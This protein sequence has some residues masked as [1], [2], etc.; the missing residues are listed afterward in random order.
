MRTWKDYKNNPNVINEAKVVIKTIEGA[1]DYALENSK[2]K[3]EA[4]AFIS[5]TKDAFIVKNLQQIKEML[6]K[7]PN[8]IF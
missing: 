4:I 3:K 1:L 5:K 7:L 6:N 8:S 2:N